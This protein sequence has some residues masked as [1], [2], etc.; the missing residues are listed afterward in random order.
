MALRKNVAV[1][2][3]MDGLLLDTEPIYRMAWQKAASDLGY[4][5][6]DDFYLNLIGRNNND[7]E[8][9]LAETFR[10]DFSLP[11]FRTTWVRYWHDYV[12][13]N[14]I[15]QKPGASELVNL[16]EK[17]GIPRALATSADRKEAIMSLGEL[18][19]SFNTI[20]TGDQI[21]KSKPSPDIFIT[22]ARRLQIPP[23]RCL[24][25]EDSEV[26]IKAAH[27]AG[28]TSIMVPDLKQPSKEVDSM[29][30]CICS[31]L[32]E[33]KDLVIQL[34]PKMQLKSITT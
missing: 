19:N 9:I 17:H 32:Y 14:G 4:T 21:K 23:E 22:A 3:D 7:A 15:P 25:L 29:V 33:V 8:A 24:V 34:T 28:M 10:D 1:I 2:F 30:Y 6:S 20:I 13:K 31:S 27:S 11:E 18:K 26:G 16:L 12:Q 5:I